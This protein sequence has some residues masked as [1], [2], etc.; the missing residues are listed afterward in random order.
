MA[1]I[2]CMA[3]SSTIEI[4]QGPNPT[5]GVCL[6]CW[7]NEKAIRADMDRT[8]AAWRRERERDGSSAV[9]AGTIRNLENK[10]KLLS[11]AT[12]EYKRRMHAAEKAHEELSALHCK[13]A[14]ENFLFRDVF[15]I[16]KDAHTHEVS[17]GC[18]CTT[19]RPCPELAALKE[20]AL[21]ETPEYQCTRCRDNEP[22]IAGMRA[23]L[24]ELQNMM[25]FRCS[26]CESL[27]KRCPSCSE[28]RR[29]LRMMS[30]EALSNRLGA[31]FLKKV[32]N[33]LHDFSSLG[34]GSAILYLNGTYN[35]TTFDPEELKVKGVNLALHSIGGTPRGAVDKWLASRKGKEEHAAPAPMPVQQIT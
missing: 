31:E 12:E 2:R 14:R 6:N 28:R 13:V 10:N 23:V 21:A 16:W 26:E 9:T 29:K 27:K 20:A 22:V 11:E 15:Q 7:E 5:V 30:S 17:G 19:R 4:P 24:E 34:E 32:K 25:G 33:G 18:L 1:S 35:V 8:L 3:C